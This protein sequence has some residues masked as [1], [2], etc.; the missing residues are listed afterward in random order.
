MELLDQPSP[1][2]TPMKTVSE[3]EVATVFSRSVIILLV[4]MQLSESSY[5]VI[6]YVLVISQAHLFNT[7]TCQPERVTK[8]ENIVYCQNK[9]KL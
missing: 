8:H 2:D 3:T 7:M 4:V 9:F 5:S 6:L 1:D